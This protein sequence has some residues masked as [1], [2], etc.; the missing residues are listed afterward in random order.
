MS[1]R[2]GVWIHGCQGRMGT[3][4]RAALE[5]HP[6][7][8]LVGGSDH[9]EHHPLLDDFGG[10]RL[11]L[12]F[13]TPEGNRLLASI[14]S[15]ST[16]K[17]AILIGTTGLDEATLSLWGSEP[18]TRERQILIA[19]N[20]SLGILAMNLALRV[21]TRALTEQGFDM[22]LIETHHRAK[23]DAPSGTAKLLIQSALAECAFDTQ[24]VFQRERPRQSG[25]LGVHSIRGG[26]VFGEHEMRFLSDHEELSIGHRAFSRG[27]FARG[28]LTFGQWL[29]RQPCG[30]YQYAQLSSLLEPRPA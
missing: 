26:G 7:F 22:E 9:D 29:T 5:H 30:L 17:G 4:L 11:I 15:K 12:D 10:A 14:L 8:R 1:H 2:I 6:D 23:K 18:L 21:V 20:T 13:S 16:W 28:A 25:E 19:P 24:S 3:E 27:L